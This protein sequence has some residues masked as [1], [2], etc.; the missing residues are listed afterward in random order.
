M[1]ETYQVH[2]TRID[3]A[4][5]T[6]ALV[7]TVH[8]DNPAHTHDDQAVAQGHATFDGVEY[9]FEV[10]VKGDNAP[11]YWWHGRA[12]V[13]E[14]DLRTVYGENAIGLHSNNKLPLRLGTPAM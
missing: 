4:M 2:K 5:P 6:P 7:W 3:A 1:A 11:Q 9:D 10:H 12:V 13:G 8:T 14:H